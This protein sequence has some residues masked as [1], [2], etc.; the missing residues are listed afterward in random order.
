[1]I[2]FNAKTPDVEY[3]ENYLVTNVTFGTSQCTTFYNPLFYTETLLNPEIIPESA[4]Y[5]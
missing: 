5:D 2:I 4:F 1:M 3:V